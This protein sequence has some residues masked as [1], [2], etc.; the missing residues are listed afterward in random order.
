M[1]P[2]DLKPLEIALAEWQKDYPAHVTAQQK[3]AEQKKLL[4]KATQESEEEKKLATASY[5]V[6]IAAETQKQKI[7]EAEGEAQS[8]QIKA[9]AQ[10]EAYRQIAEIAAV[11][12]ECGQSPAPALASAPALRTD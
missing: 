11:C 8:T 10:A 4:A 9:K 2:T 7:T 6:K 1:D 5:S 12:P 3:A